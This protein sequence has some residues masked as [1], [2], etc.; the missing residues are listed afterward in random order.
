M[1]RKA[2]FD[3]EAMAK[4]LTR[5]DGLITRRQAC[6]CGLSDSA[7]RHRLRSGGPWQVLLPGVYGSFTGAATRSQRE[8]AAILYAGPDSVITG[9]SALTWH[10]IRAPRTSIVSVLIPEP[11]RRRDVGFVR[12]SRTSRMPRMVFPSGAVCYVPPA[13]AVADTVRGLRD[14]GDV[15]AVVADGVQRG[16]V[17]VRQ[18]ADELANGP[19]QGSARLRLVLGEIAEGV[20]SVAEAD[21]RVLIKRERLPDPMYNA[22][23][24]A[25]GTFIASPDAWWPRAG[26]AAEVDSREWHL[27]PQDWERTLARHAR[28]SAHGIIVLH[29]P[30]ARLR[31]EPRAV[32]AEIRSAL[33]AGR[34]RPALNIKALPTR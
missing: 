8:L 6:D 16:A 34:D 20:R 25:D 17:Q 12:L 1:G 22:R 26:V 21:L 14:I 9:P 19:A 3:R 33:A 30:P 13:R 24:L 32:A 10:R 7:L 2:F 29:F 15:R 18:L 27:S 31:T 23:L 11:R 28:M 5:Q 4:L